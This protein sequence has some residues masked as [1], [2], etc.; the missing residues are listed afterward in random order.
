V[1]PHVVNSLQRGYHARGDTL[2][3][4]IIKRATVAL[5]AGL[6]V[7]AASAE[8]RLD[9]YFIDVEGG[10]STLIVTPAGQ[11]LLIDAGYP[12]RGGRDPD[13]ILSAVRDAGIRRIDYM[14]VTHFHEDHDGGVAELSRRIPIGTYVDYGA[15]TQ[16]A[17]EVVAAFAAYAQARAHG[18]HLQPSPGDR[19]PLNGLEVDIVAAGG[20]T[21]SKPLADG[22]QPNAACA[23]F[24]RRADNTTE[25][26]RSIGVLVQF[27]AFRF[28]DLGD[29]VWNRLGD[30]VCPVNLI[31]RADVYLLA[32]H[33]NPDANVPALLAAVEPRVAIVNNGAYKGGAASVLASLHQIA[34]LEDVWQLHRSENDGAENFAD[35]QIANLVD[36]AK[37]TAAWI[38]LAAGSDGSF[39]MTNA[40]SGF[41]KDY[42]RTSEKRSRVRE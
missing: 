15:P 37:D 11:S 2:T 25:N 40:R 24:E 42:G 36:G 6:A 27:G 41:Q 33:G 39:S 10:Q 28:L 14:L 23:T 5:V 9:I 21:L 16:T 3:S 17:P 4:R 26:P 32:H 20:R 38:K 18:K 29:L 12:D 30:L 35:Q 34:A 19:L 8:K 22:G 31:G 1:A 13:R 7:T